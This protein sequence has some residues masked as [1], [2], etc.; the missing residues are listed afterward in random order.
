VRETNLPDQFLKE[1]FRADVVEVRR[2]DDEEQQTVPVLKAFPQVV[3]DW[4]IWGQTNDRSG[5]KLLTPQKRAEEKNIG[6]DTIP[7]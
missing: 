7:Q 1:W 2:G 3:F 6:C 4:E 5:G